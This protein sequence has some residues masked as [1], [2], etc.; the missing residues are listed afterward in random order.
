MF[1][2]K[3]LPHQ[4]YSGKVVALSISIQSLLVVC[5]SGCKYAPV[6]LT[7]NLNAIN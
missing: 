6:K 5:A 7:K 3:S 4:N 1:V 2:S